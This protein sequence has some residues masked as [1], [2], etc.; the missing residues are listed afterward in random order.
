[1]NKFEL[2]KEIIDFAAP[3][4]RNNSAVLAQKNKEIASKNK[5][6]N[7]YNNSIQRVEALSNRRAPEMQ[8]KINNIK[9][10][11]PDDDDPNDKPGEEKD[12]IENQY[13][14]RRATMV[15][16]L[17]DKMKSDILLAGIHGGSQILNRKR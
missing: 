1:M 6:R 9:P 15:Q 13:R 8:K 16:R 11:D 4:V 17:K 10:R 14:E 3:S 7:N 12:R 5:I 2:I